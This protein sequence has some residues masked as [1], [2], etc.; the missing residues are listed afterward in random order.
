MPFGW[1]GVRNLH[2]LHKQCAT[3]NRGW[4]AMIHVHVA[5][6]GNLKNVVYIRIRESSTLT[7]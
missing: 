6:V 5:V 4:V 2:L 7:P 1:N 3:V